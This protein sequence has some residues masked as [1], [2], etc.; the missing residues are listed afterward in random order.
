MIDHA[1]KELRTCGWLKTSS[2]VTFARLLK[3]PKVTKPF[4]IA[5][6]CETGPASREGV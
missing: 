5:G 4:S 3:L 2:I 1:N 6:V